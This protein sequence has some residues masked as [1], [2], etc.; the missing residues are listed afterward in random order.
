MP[1]GRIL[2]EIDEDGTPTIEVAGITGKGCLALTKTLEDALG[3]VTTRTTTKDY[4]V[5]EQAPI[6]QTHRQ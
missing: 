3:S 5:R 6:Q 4:T 2:V 1:K